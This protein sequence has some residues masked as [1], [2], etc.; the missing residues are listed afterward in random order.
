MLPVFKKTQAFR[1]DNLLVSLPEAK[2]AAGAYKEERARKRKR[3]NEMGP[4]CSKTDDENRGTV[5]VGN[6]TMI[7]EGD[8]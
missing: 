6:R 4:G 1:M 7:K 5:E 2:A 8:D 3:A